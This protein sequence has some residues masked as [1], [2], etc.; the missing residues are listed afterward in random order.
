MLV[1]LSLPASASTTVC[2]GDILNRSDSLILPM[3]VL[4]NSKKRRVFGSPLFA[5]FA[6]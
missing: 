3:I 1:L 5:V 4:L 2:F 6:L